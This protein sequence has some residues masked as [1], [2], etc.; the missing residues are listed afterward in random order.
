MPLWLTV[1]PSHIAADTC[2]GDRLGLFCCGCSLPAPLTSSVVVSVDPKVIS[3]DRSPSLIVSTYP[4]AYCSRAV[5]PVLPPKL[6]ETV[7]DD[8]PSTHSNV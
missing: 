5:V 3:D 7:L 1:C 4:L 8:S 2:S 6:A